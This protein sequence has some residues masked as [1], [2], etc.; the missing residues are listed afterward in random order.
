MSE[1]F[2]NEADMFQLNI[3]NEAEEITST[4]ILFSNHLLASLQRRLL[5]YLKF[6]LREFTP[7]NFI[8]C[9]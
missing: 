1:K 2:P 6:A 9:V 3:S 8:I 7:I 5:Y 4:E